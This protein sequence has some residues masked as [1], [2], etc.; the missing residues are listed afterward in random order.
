MHLCVKALCTIPAVQTALTGARDLATFVKFRHT[1]WSQ[2]WEQYTTDNDNGATI[3]TSAHRRRVPN[4]RGPAETRWSSFYL[5]VHDILEHQHFIQHYQQHLQMLVAA[6]S[7]KNGPAQ[8][9]KWKAVAITDAEF[10]FLRAMDSLLSPIYYAQK[11]MQSSDMSVGASASRF[12]NL[13]ETLREQFLELDATLKEHGLTAEELDSDQHI[14]LK[15]ES[16]LC[17]IVEVFSPQLPRQEAAAMGEGN[18]H[19]GAFPPLLSRSQRRVAMQKP[20]VAAALRALRADA[21]AQEEEARQS[22]R[23]GAVGTKRRRQ[24]SPPPQTGRPAGVATGSADGMEHPAKRRR[25]GSRRITAAPATEASAPPVGSEQPIAVTVNAPHITEE[26]AGAAIDLFDDGGSVGDGAEDEL[27]EGPRK[28]AND[29]GVAAMRM[30]RV[31]VLHTSV[32]VHKRIIG[33]G[34]ELATRGSTARQYT[35]ASAA[36]DPTASKALTKWV[37]GNDETKDAVK[38]IADFFLDRDK[39]LQERA[40]RVVESPVKVAAGQPELPDWAR[41]LNKQRVAAVEAD[42]SVGWIGEM[43]V[44]IAQHMVLC[45][46]QHMVTTLKALNNTCTKV[47]KSEKDKSAVQDALVYFYTISGNRA[48]FNAV[49]CALDDCRQ[50]SMLAATVTKKVMIAVN[51]RLWYGGGQA[52]DAPCPV[53]WEGIAPPM[54]DNLFENNERWVQ[55]ICGTLASRQRAVDGR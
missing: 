32:A 19:G 3:D 15:Q 51:A 2:V 4:I 45:A 39:R 55:I 26:Q 35:L 1:I 18:E 31:A 27:G 53:P 22:S 43:R 48:E 36:L 29:D 30:L 41:T 7:I 6:G 50:S 25:V 24:P 10:S 13:R 5:T 33:P 23:E 44:S 46:R 47:F 40:L 17:A 28:S 20:E 12:L 38:A 14:L 21:E 42:A 11:D 54:D 37:S 34:H 8:L 49:T 9:S 52:A 16:F